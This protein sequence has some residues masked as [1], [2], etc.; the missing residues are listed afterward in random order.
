MRHTHILLAGACSLL[1]STAAMAQTAPDAISPQD[2][3]QLKVLEW[4]PAKGEYKEWTAVGGE[5]TVASDNTVSIPFVGA[6]STALRS[7]EKLSISIADS[8]QRGLSLPTRPDVQIQYVSRAPV[9]VLGGVETPGRIEYTAG[10]T[11]IEAVALAGGFYRG[12]GSARLERDVINAEGDLSEAQESQERLTAKILRLEAELADAQRIEVPKERATDERLV[13]FV[14]EQQNIMDVRRQGRLSQLESLRS[15]EKLATDQSRTIV[16]K[17]G[18][19]ASQVELT[20]TQLGSVQSLVDKGLT[21]ASRSFELRRTLAELEGKQLDLDIARLSANLEI[22][23]AQRDQVDV[24]TQFNA[25][26][27]NEL[28]SSR[29]E[30]AK[31]DLAIARAELLVREATVIA[32]EQMLDRAGN[33]QVDIA[34]YVTRR[35]GD[36]TSTRKVG[37]DETLQPGDT[38]QIQLDLD[39]D[40]RGRNS[41]SLD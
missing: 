8:L 32:P 15:R 9:Y 5:Y 38:V 23:E 21:V 40:G 37:R 29:S 26:V 18:N 19:N 36:S 39:A 41:A 3:L 20:K 33:A 30:L 11:A 25:D 28:Q 35:A 17:I 22:N 13:R 10:M 34:I 31:V 12:G 4:L 7:P 27:V 2:K 16:E 14:A 6:I 24:V 1:F